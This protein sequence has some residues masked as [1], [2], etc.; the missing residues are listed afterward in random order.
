[1]EKF[2]IANIG[3]MSQ[4]LSREFIFGL[5]RFKIIARFFSYALVLKKQHIEGYFQTYFLKNVIQTIGC[6]A[7]GGTTSRP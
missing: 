6:Y 2:A 7:L 1:M 4:T 5:A 3:Q